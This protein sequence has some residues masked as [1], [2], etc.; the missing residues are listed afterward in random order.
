MQALYQFLR[1]F[2]FLRIRGATLG[3]YRIYGPV[4]F[5]ALATAIVF[6]LPLEIKITQ[7]KSLADYMA[8]LFST[9]PG[10]FIAALAAVVAFSGGDLDKVMPDV[11]LSITANGDTSPVEIT[12]RV[13][14][15]YLFSYLT[16]VS[17]IGFF[18][19]VSGTL[20]ALNAA[21]LVSLIESPELREIIGTSLK[22]GFVYS[23]LFLV[24]SVL[25]CTML[26]LYFLAERVHQSLLE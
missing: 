13:F 20:V 3:F 21:K 8:S 1:P 24:A 16:I 22:L 18:V 17:F 12:L 23:V 26:G 19:C 7:D 25:F 9:L 2:A 4:L 14:L 15:S 10:F 5:A 11:K 6:L